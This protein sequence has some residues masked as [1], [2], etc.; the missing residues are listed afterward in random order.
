MFQTNKLSQHEEISIVARVALSGQPVARIG[1]WEGV[2]ESFN[3][4][5]LDGPVSILISSQIK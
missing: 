2:V 5:R 1:D 4:T 3:R